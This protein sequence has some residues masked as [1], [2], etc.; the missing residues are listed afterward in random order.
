MPLVVSAAGPEMWGKSTKKVVVPGGDSNG[1]VYGL[2]YCMDRSTDFFPRFC[3]RGKTFSL[4]HRRF[5]R[6]VLSV[7]IFL[8]RALLKAWC[9]LQ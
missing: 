8:N 3:T 4:S 1:A 6:G 2:R 5:R 9:H 7:S